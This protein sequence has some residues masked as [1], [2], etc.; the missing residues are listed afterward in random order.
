MSP[1]PPVAVAANDTHTEVAADRALATECVQMPPIASRWRS[2]KVD[3]RLLSPK[4]MRKRVGS[5]KM[6]RLGE[7]HVLKGP[8]MLDADTVVSYIGHRT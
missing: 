4:K 8:E 6:R 3:E 7:R 1:E 5:R 2:S